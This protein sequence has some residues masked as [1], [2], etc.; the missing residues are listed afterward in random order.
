MRRLLTQAHGRQPS[1]DNGSL[2]SSDL[3]PW[4]RALCA[5]DSGDTV[6]QRHSPHSEEA[7]SQI[8]KTDVHQMISQTHGRGGKVQ[9]AVRPDLVGLVVARDGLLEKVRFCALI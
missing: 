6:S 4:Y 7:P 1:L 8:Q 2:A 9:E 3:A 5:P